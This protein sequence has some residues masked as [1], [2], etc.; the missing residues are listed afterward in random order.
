MDAVEVMRRSYPQKISMLNWRSTMLRLCKQIEGNKLFPWSSSAYKGKC[1]K[2]INYCTFWCFGFNPWVGVF[3]TQF[4]EGN[5]MIHFLKK[6]TFICFRILFLFSKNEFQE[7]ETSFGA[8]EKW[9]CEFV[10]E[11]FYFTPF[12]FHLNFTFILHILIWTY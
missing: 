8:L 3:Q 1:A 6:K 5:A 4:G 9:V 10:I 12:N 11:N 7:F 2:Q